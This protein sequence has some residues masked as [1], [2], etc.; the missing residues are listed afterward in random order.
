MS[1]KIDEQFHRVLNEQVHSTSISAFARLVG[2]GESTIRKYLAGSSPT[3]SKFQQIVDRSG[4]GWSIWL[5]RPEDNTPRIDSR[6]WQQSEGFIQ[7]YYEDLSQGGI[8][9]EH[10]QLQFWVY[11]QLI[12]GFSLQKIYQQLTVE[13]VS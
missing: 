5:Q 9:L 12:K 13:R 3:L 1:I 4:L 2:L 8:Q 7:L 6:L 10:Q 11:Q